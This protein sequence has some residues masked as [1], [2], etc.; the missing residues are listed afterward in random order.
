METRDDP[1]LI[2]YLNQP[3]GTPE[4]ALLQQQSAPISRGHTYIP[5]P[6]G[7]RVLSIK[8][9]IPIRHHEKE[10]FVYSLVWTANALLPAVSP[11]P[12]EN[13]KAPSQVLFCF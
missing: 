2:K 13:K 7:E 6:F 10:K 9:Q 3:E 12:Q 4:K 1:M 5:P 11:G 8:S